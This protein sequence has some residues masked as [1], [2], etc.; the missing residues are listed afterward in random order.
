MS[1]R[2]IVLGASPNPARY[3]YMATAKLA[4]YG[5][6][7]FPIGLRGGTIEGIE[8][9][10]E[11]KHID[12]IDTLTLYIGPQNESN[13]KDY[14]LMINPKRVIFNPGAENPAFEKL[15]NKQGIITENA[16]TLVMLSV[17]K[18]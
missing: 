5:H 18:F 8:I 2:S 4:A 7:V 1:K 16:C 9:I 12:N 3:S 11:Q 15:L 13:Y 17:G 10:T 6:E 14:I